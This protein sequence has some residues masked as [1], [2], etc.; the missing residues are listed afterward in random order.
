MKKCKRFGNLNYLLHKRVTV[1]KKDMA[2][3][4]FQ[5][6][7]SIIVPNWAYFH[8]INHLKLYLTGVTIRT[9]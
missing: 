5:M 3:D 7:L 1:S 8:L 6:Q 2:I 4:R 9:S